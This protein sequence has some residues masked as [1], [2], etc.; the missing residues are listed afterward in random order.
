MAPK[1]INNPALNDIASGVGYL[2]FMYNG[3]ESRV[4]TL[5][6]YL[7]QMKDEDLE[8]LATPIDLKK[9]LPMLKAFAF[10]KKPSELW[11]HDIDLMI[12][13][14]NHYIIP[15]RNRYVHDVW[16]SFPAGAIRRYERTRISKPQSRKE[17][18][19]TTYEIIPT[20]ADDV[21]SLVQDTKDVSNIIR[22]LHAAHRAGTAATHPEQS[23][24]Q[25]YRDQWLARRKSQKGSN[26]EG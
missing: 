3:L 1:R 5:I 7:A 6:G 15:L 18:E 23:F 14:I 11:M 25:Q 12:W 8:I 19:L 24:P 21:W 20:S 26:G 22:L 10:K 13:A 17:P 2:C 16:L 4:T 9:K